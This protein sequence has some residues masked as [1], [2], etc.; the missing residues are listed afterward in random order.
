MSD[1]KGKL[2]SVQRPIDLPP[3]AR[4]RGL[5]GLTSRERQVVALLRLSRS[6]KE[7]AYQLGIADST[8][9]V[10]LSRASAK[11]G[12][13]S[14]AELVRVATLDPLPELPDAKGAG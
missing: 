1:D 2:Q 10:L 7:I 6:T 13:R 8:A 12:V 14:R 4:T 5:A 11:M 9:R 3:A